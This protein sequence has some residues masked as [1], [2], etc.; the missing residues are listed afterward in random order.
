MES[1]Y[2]SKAVYFLMSLVFLM[3]FSLSAFAMDHKEDHK[4][5]NHG[6]STKVFFDFRD[7]SPT[8]A[9]IHLKL[10]HDTYNDK[11]F[12]SESPKFAV[13]F[14]GG[15]VNLLS[16]KNREKYSSEDRKKLEEIDKVIAAM[17]KDGIR[18][19]V[20]LFAVKVF[21]LAPDSIL[22]E[23]KQVDNG[24]IASVRYQQKGY[25]QVP[26]F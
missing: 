24:W 21:G 15:S 18:L 19:E 13:V 9:L 10:I 22:K 11:E 5:M 20:C 14:M 3:T 12:A 26:V 8:S 16:T 23:I 4:S 6:N 2:K 7:S 1:I 17:S 25:A